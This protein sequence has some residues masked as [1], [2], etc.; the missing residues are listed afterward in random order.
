MR[1][2]SVLIMVKNSCSVEGCVSIAYVNRRTFCYKHAPPIKDCQHTGCST[3]IKYG[4]FC[5]LHKKKCSKKDCT[6]NVLRGKEVCAKHSSKKACLKEGCTNKTQSL[7]YCVRHRVSNIC[8][9]V[10]CTKYRCCRYKFCTEHGGFTVCK[11][12]NCSTPAYA[13]RHKYCRLHTNKKDKTAQDNVAKGIIKIIHSKKYV[14]GPSIWW[15]GCNIRGCNKCGHLNNGKYRCKSHMRFCKKVNCSNKIYHN[16]LCIKHYKK[17]KC[18]IQNCAYLAIKGYDR[19]TT[20]GGGKKCRAK[21]CATRASH[22]GRCRYHGRRCK[23]KGCNTPQCANK[24]CY[25]HQSQ[26]YKDKRNAKVRY[27]IENNSIFKLNKR[28]RNRF[29]IAFKCS[30]QINRK[31]YFKKYIGLTVVELWEYLESLF[32]PGMTRKNY[33]KWHIDHIKPVCSFDLSSD[34]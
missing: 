5:V 20:H 14:R 30:N 12:K 17:V 7:K 34:E 26:E 3:K 2:S 10:G 27:R 4:R 32:E 18:V 21:G 23:H 11:K 6:S 13:N 25:K 24:K 28:V 31:F 9:F 15:R 16:Y 8:T 33:G 19:C 29:H 1:A 22:F